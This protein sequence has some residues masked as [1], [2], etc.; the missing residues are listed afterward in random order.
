M[1]N[2]YIV[3]FKT[4]VRD[5]IKFFD[6]H[7]RLNRKDMD[8]GYQQTQLV[9][10]IVNNSLSYSSELTQSRELPLSGTRN[11]LPFAMGQYS[12]VIKVLDFGG[13]AG[14]HHTEAELAF[15]DKNF[16][17]IVF[18][19]KSMVDEVNSKSRKTEVTFIHEMS[20]LE[21]CK[22]D[23]IIANSSL[24]YTDNPIQVM[25]DLVK[26]GAKYIYISPEPPS[27]TE[28]RSHFLKNQILQITGPK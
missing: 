15:P 14:H 18:E 6:F 13:G 2:D 5:S 16:E 1:K 19:T 3:R 22:F 4:K 8:D 26:L 12:D 9:S 11:Y 21:G 27:P 10:H 7:G 28:A 23:L 17:W 25:T 24:Q 20:K